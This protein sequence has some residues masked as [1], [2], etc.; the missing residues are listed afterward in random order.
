MRPVSVL[1]CLAALT[2]AALPAPAF[3]QGR[4]LD[5]VTEA[6]GFD[7]KRLER[8]AML[9]AAS[10]ARDLQNE[11]L[12]EGMLARALVGSGHRWLS[13]STTRVL[14][15]NAAPGDS[16]LNGVRDEILKEGRLDSLSA[17]RVCEKLRVDAVLCV[18]IDR[19]EQVT[20]EPTQS[21]KP[22]TTVQVRAALMGQDGRMLWSISGS[23]IG[24]G[25]YQSPSSNPYRTPGGGV[26]P[27][28]TSTG[29]GAPSFEEVLTKLFDRW[30]PRFP[31]RPVKDAG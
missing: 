25:S 2:A 27:N 12:V 17:L 8:I 16:L 13:T 7:A 26:N 18:R 3:A 10:F 31:R 6:P 11:K 19:F 14:L 24:E 4:S 15:R 5:T 30:G 20:L 1:A 9:P 29:I 23:E 28:P 22:S 21:G